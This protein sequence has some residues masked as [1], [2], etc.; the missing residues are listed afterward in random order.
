MEDYPETIL[1]FEKRFATEEA[2]AGNILP[3]YA[4]LR[5]SIAP[6]VAARRPGQ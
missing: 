1:E 4:G 5:A 3:G 2:C 6:D